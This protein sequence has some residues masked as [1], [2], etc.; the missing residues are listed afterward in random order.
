MLLRNRVS[1]FKSS[2]FFF[3]DYAEVLGVPYTATKEE[4][5]AA[6]TRKSKQWHPDAEHGSS[7][8]FNL[9]RDAYETLQDEQMKDLHFKYNLS[10]EG[11][12]GFQSGNFDVT[13]FRLFMLYRGGFYDDEN[14]FRDVD[15]YF[16]NAEYELKRRGV[17]PRFGGL[18]KRRELEVNLETEVGLKEAVE[19]ASRT[20]EYSALVTC[21]DCPTKSF[22]GKRHANCQNCSGFSTNFYDL[23]P[24]KVKMTCEESEPDRCPS[25]DGKGYIKKTFQKTITI[26][27]GVDNDTIVVINDEYTNGRV[28]GDK[29]K[30]NVHF[31]YV[32]DRKIERSG[33]DLFIRE[34]ISIA[35]AFYGTTKRVKVGGKVIDVE[36]PKIDEWDCDFQYT[37]IEKGRGLF[38]QNTNLWGDLYVTFVPKIP[39][40]E[41]NDLFRLFSNLVR[42]SDDD[43]EK[44]GEGAEEN[45]VPM[46]KEDLYKMELEKLF[47]ENKTKKI[48]KK[49]RK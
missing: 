4:L 3:K 32:P 22:K 44:D 38:D 24:L 34:D 36:V 23:G 27:K 8:M 6:F 7:R 5:K 14:F 12:E 31:N 42:S 45:A 9:V 33:N 11:I 29:M 37:K 40:C 25:C 16:E 47:S 19:G 13:N 18:V 39:K 48:K 10:L 21:L 15:R 41:T 49:K 46:S 28:K 1:L 35:Q 2:N 43:A 20:V 17:Y 30:V 26:P